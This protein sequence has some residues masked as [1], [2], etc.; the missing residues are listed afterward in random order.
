MFKMSLFDGMVFVS[1]P[2]ADSGNYF[3]PLLWEGNADLIGMA[4]FYLE[5]AYGAFGHLFDLEFSS[6]IDLHYACLSSLADYAP[7][8]IEGAEYVEV[9]DPGIPEGAV[10]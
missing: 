5:S 10:T 4:K 1:I 3:G 9:Y 2:E 6:P 8:V 7:E